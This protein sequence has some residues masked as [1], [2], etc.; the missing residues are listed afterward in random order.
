MR[1][2]LLSLFLLSQG[3]LAVAQPVIVG[4]ERTRIWKPLV[5]G[6]KVGLVVNPTSRVGDQHLVDRML[7]EGVEVVKVFAPEH[8]FRGEADAGAKIEDGTDPS[9]GLPIVSLYG[10][11][12]KPSAEM[13]AD[14]DVV[15]F[16]IQDV[17]ARFYT[18]ISTMHYV[19]EACAENGKRMVVLDRPNPNGDYV[20]GPVRHPAYQSFVAMHPIPVVHGLT[21]GELA[22]MINGEGWLAD[23]RV[24]DL[25]VVQLEGWDHAQPYRL[26][27]APSPNLP[28]QQSIRWYPSLCLLEGTP[29][30]VG[31]GTAWPFQVAGFPSH[32]YGDFT[33]RPVSVPG[34]ATYPKHQ[35]LT[36]YGMDLRE[37]ESP[38]AF[39]LRIVMD[40]YQKTP[41]AE[42][43]AFFEPFFTTLAGTPELAEQISA[44]FSEE[45]IR[46]SWKADL[47]AY[48]VMRKQYL[49]YPDFEE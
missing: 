47:D 42:R 1:V 45:E 14:L 12:K 22:Q 38:G 39:S 25:T 40:M 21:V 23:S 49:L 2:L 9:T 26:P 7:A 27:V 31:R 35:N 41:V 34:K 18:Y 10:R 16:D 15:V 33:F 20:D 13:L 3:I 36:C 37:E 8:G 28:N 6:Q 19:M 30:S 46:W 44:N 48:K 32:T 4:A 29:I 5:R 43:D 11:N 24:C 17:G